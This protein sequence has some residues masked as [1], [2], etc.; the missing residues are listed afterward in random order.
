VIKW[1]L[2][3][4]NRRE[5]LF[6]GLI[7]LYMALIVLFPD[8]YKELFREPLVSSSDLAFREAGGGR[9]FGFLLIFMQ[10]AEFIALR[11]KTHLVLLRIRETTGKRVGGVALFY[12]WTFHC[13]TAVMLGRLAM[14]AFGLDF[15]KDQGWSIFLLFAIV[16]KELFLLA[17]MLDIEGLDEDSQALVIQ[18]QE[19]FWKE[20]TADIVLF[21]FAAITYTVFWESQAYD[22]GSSLASSRSSIGSLL[23]EGTGALFLFSI[24]FLPL[25]V[26]WL[27]ELWYGKEPVWEKLAGVIS[28]VSVAFVALVPLFDGATNLEAALADPAR[29]TKLYIQ[30]KKIS[31]LPQDIDSLKQLEV[32]YAK[33][34]IIATLPQEIGELKSL[35]YLNL[36]ANRIAELPRQIGAIPE[37]QYL[38]LRGNQLTSLPPEISS[39]KHLRLL[40]VSNNRLRIVPSSLSELQDLSELILTGNPL[41][42]TAIEKLR[43][44]MPRTKIVF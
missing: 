29:A 6:N 34:G 40:D 25:K 18:K 37:L 17:V 10:V 41:P 23:V 4:A 3:V 14:Q 36:E 7:G 35:R 30:D 32:L 21:F 33:R 27:I 42:K 44:E 13:V 1:Q 11:W 9:A 24:L 38:Y 5:A 16:I 20:N 31:G 39:L 26:P 12:L 15:D 2:P 8:V 43:K 19:S 22:P 28:L